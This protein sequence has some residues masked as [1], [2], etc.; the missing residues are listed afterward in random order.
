MFFSR[1]RKKHVIPDEAIDARQISI[2]ASQAAK[3]EHTKAKLDLKHA[4]HV[5][6]NLEQIREK[7]HFAESLRISFGKEL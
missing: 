7:N 3:V 4:M 6:G 2:E 1:R 5:M